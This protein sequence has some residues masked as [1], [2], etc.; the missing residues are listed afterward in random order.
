MRVVP[1]RYLGEWNIEAKSPDDFV[2]DL[3]GLD[4]RIVYSCVQEISAGRRNPPTSF[5]DVLALLERSG[6]IEAAS[7]LR[8][9]PTPIG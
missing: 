1:Q 8:S 4:N 2:L 6:L 9:G 5:E 7:A 3:I